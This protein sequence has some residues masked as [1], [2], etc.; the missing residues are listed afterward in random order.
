MVLF[1]LPP[2]ITGLPEDINDNLPAGASF[3]SNDTRVNGYY[4]PCPT[5]GDNNRYCFSVYA[6]DTLLNLSPDTRRIELMDAIEGHILA[7][8]ELMGIY[9]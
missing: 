7:W 4:G 6:L 1:G 9:R 2:D 3:G 5:A 8:G